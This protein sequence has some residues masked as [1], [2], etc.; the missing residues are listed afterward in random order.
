MTVERLQSVLSGIGPPDEDGPGV[1]PREIA[2]ILWL[3]AHIAEEPSAPDPAEPEA[4]EAPQVRPVEEPSESRPSAPI[5]APTA[6]VP[7]P[8]G[9]ELRTPAAASSAE[10]TG[11]ASV[12]VPTA[13]M[14]DHPLAVQRALRPLKRRVPDRRTL[15]LDEQATAAR[16][17][18]R[19]L[20]VRPW[21]PVLTA[22]PERWLSLVLV[23]DDG[24]SMRLW[25]PLARELHE[26]FLR[27]GA[28]RDLRVCRLVGTGHG[29]G[30]TV[31]P[32]APPRDAATLVDPS[33]RQ[34]VLV[35]SDCSGPYWWDGSAGR[36]LH[37]WAQ[38]GP[39]AILQPLTERL[40]RR[41]AAPTVPGGIVAARGCAPNTALRFTPYD[42]AGARPG[43]VPVP[44]LEC[45]P[46]WFTDW[47]TLVAG[48][49]ARPAAVTYVDGR[50]RRSPE[51]VRQ[52]HELPIRE[53][54]RRF[55]STASP[56]AARLA[57][58]VAVSFPALPVMRL[59]QQR[60]LR[61]SHPGHLAEVLLS[62]LL[63]PVG[64]ERYDFVPGARRAL[65][66]TLPRSESWH[67]ADVLARVSEEIER[68]AGSGAETFPAYLRTND[69]SGEHALGP[70]GRPF[71]LVS[72]EAIRLLNRTALPAAGPE[73][74]RPASP[75][76]AG[77]RPGN[78]FLGLL[79]VADPHE[80]DVDRLWAPL[81]D[82][83][84]LRVPLGHD[85]G[86]KPVFLDLKD[87]SE[88]GMGPHGLCV[89]STGAGKSELL[90]TLVLGLAVSHP[91]DQ[92]TML[93]I[94]YKGSATFA[95]F[96]GLPHVAG[97]VT[98][99]EDAPALV[100]RA[101]A[102][103]DGE[104]ERRLR[105][106][107][108]NVFAEVRP[109]GSVVGV[110]RPPRLLVIVDEFA[111]LL[112]TQ[113]GFISLFA[114]LGRV[115]RDIGIH[116]L[117]ASQLVDGRLHGLEE[118]LSYRIGLR[119][120]TEEQS[121]AVIGSTEAY[122][123][124]S[125]PGSGYLKVGDEAG[126][127][128]LAGYVSGPAEPADEFFDEYFDEGLPSDWSAPSRVVPS[129]ASVMAGQL[130]GRG[131]P[132]RRLWWPPLPSVLTLDDVGGPAEATRQGLRLA[133]D[134]GDLRVPLG[135]LDEPAQHEQGVW[136]LDLTAKG[137]HVGVI[138]SPRSG[139]TTLLRT[140]VLSLALTHTPR[141]VAV[142]AVDLVS[143]TGLRPLRT[144]PHVR[145]VAGSHDRD[146]IRSIIGWVRNILDQRETVFRDPRHRLAGPA[147]CDAR[148]RAGP[149]T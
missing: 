77:A 24:P 102:A 136:T 131:E 83:D 82:R 7:R 124:P 66:T 139:K 61:T 120:S 14:L 19:P 3:A 94:D 41:T 60:V 86:G 52:E 67:T 97:L 13:P 99:L 71:A 34:I 25:R 27:L 95:P 91:P 119:T 65:L 26:T 81:G 114:T 111:E 6:P 93:L 133:D 40:W 59:I 92:V 128:F 55:Q 69:G 54:V 146:K 15:V 43:T 132:Y 72:G 112:N 1:T 35:L 32:G 145:D 75:R 108:A 79:G 87:T 116:L 10:G 30:V 134:T 148:S 28:F 105:L 104:V 23:V 57:A 46:G 20:R 53:R 42:G 135:L 38:A 138:G 58:H 117:L 12:L 64:G 37:L 4:S 147:A 11:A 44:V 45:A 21:V 47:A 106:L 101:H 96:A 100:Q 78:R 141:Q 122:H 36:A 118:Y 140:F 49:G 80:L 5:R 115:G 68:R 85:P 51:P 9:H 107:R 88:G 76:R 130:A 129:L 31:S 144:L 63:R 109:Y 123:L 33:G 16:I 126:R 18:A 29:V 90:R 39:V 89:G 22:A 125:L 2:E 50:P 17:A 143:D 48:G 70:D 8:A 137:G 121:R 110:E 62:G 142:Y 73:R 113:P 149:R 98:D 74:P 103:L 127:R 84:F 56:E